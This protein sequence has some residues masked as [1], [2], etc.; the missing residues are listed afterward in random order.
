MEGEWEPKTE[1]GRMVKEGRFKNFDEVLATGKAIMEEEIID[2]FF[3]ELQTEYILIGQSKG[4]FGGG[5]RRPYKDTQKKVREG[6][7]VKFSYLA[8]VGN[9]DG[10][11]GIGKGSSRESL[12]AREAA[13]K[14]A[15]MNL[16]RVFRSCGSWECGCGKPHS[17]PFRVEGKHGS[18]RVILE[19][20]PRG[21]GLVAHEEAKKLLKLA[22]ITDVWSKT[23]G[24]TRSRVNLAFAVFDALK[25]TATTVI[26]EKYLQTWG[27]N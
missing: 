27:V 17:V 26:P 16:I 22:G 18:V 3:P 13:L 7:R 8:V 2:Y 25:N 20:A 4:K 19:P 21:T 14:N 6:A 10:Y 1:L 9:G 24:E 12:P 23:F 15:K 5:K 11:V